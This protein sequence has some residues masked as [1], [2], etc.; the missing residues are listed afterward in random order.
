M[1]KRTKCLLLIVMLLGLISMIT[2][3][4]SFAK[5]VTNSAWNYYLSTKGFYFS[6][7]ELGSSKITNVNNNW[8]Y[9]SINFKLKNSENDYLI[10]DYDIEYTV[11]CTIQ[12]DASSYS[13]CLLNGTD[14]N[15]YTGV[16]SSSGKCINDI[17]EFDV[18]SYNKSKCELDGY[19]WNIQES[20]KDL[21]F[22]IVKTGDKE[23]D[24]VSVLI[25]VTTT[26]PYS[27]KILGEFNLSSV[28]VQE[29]GLSVSYIENDDYSR[30]IITNSYDEDKC[31]SLKWNFNDLRID[32][33][34]KN[35]SSFGYDDGY[36][37]EIKFNITKKD[38][39]SYIFYKTVFD[40][41]YDSSAFSLIE[42]NDC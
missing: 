35:I 10:S 15:E 13:R 40:E 23:L 4:Y 2:Y 42:T 6:S 7:D 39:L 14:L 20:Y 41:I 31:V 29:R 21:Y 30:V 37:N 12:N 32:Q 25:E 38:S 24:Y 17:D 9:D 26:S 18:S 36:I 11:K 16:I 33:N 28:E 5:Y 27:K 3:G 34:N 1:N 19:K 8:N 22:D